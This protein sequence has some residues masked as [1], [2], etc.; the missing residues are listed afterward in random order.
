M[1]RLVKWSC[2]LVSGPR[3]AKGLDAWMI[4][5]Q[6]VGR[7][8]RGVMAALHLDVPLRSVVVGAG[9]AGRVGT[10]WIGCPPLSRARVG[11]AVCSCAGGCPILCTPMT[12]ER[13]WCVEQLGDRFLRR[14]SPTR[15][16]IGRAWFLELIGEDHARRSCQAVISA[17]TNP[18]SSR[19]TAVATTVR[20]SLR[21]A[22]RRNRP[23]NRT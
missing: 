5:V 10:R 2:N 12:V 6:A 17:H 19:A 13:R 16:A 4:R 14:R 8:C 15:P 11:T 23:H 1:E 20:R 22:R 7:R 18:A 3:R 21:A 9:G